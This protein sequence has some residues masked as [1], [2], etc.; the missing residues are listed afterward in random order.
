[1]LIF[2]YS[3]ARSSLRRSSCLPRLSRSLMTLREVSPTNSQRQ[4][5]VCYIF[6]I[7]FTFF[8]CS[9]CF[10]SWICSASASAMI[11]CSFCC[12]TFWLSKRCFVSSSWSFSNCSSPCIRTQRWMHTCIQSRHKRSVYSGESLKQKVG[13]SFPACQ[14]CCICLQSF[15][16]NCKDT[17]RSE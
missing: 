15:F 14:Y 12:S 13:Q 4:I 9:S 16:S 8:T 11:F 7:H 5:S 17:K 2:S 1:M 3:S 10:F 6:F